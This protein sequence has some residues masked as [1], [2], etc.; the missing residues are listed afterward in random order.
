LTEAIHARGLKTHIET[1]GS[2]PLSGQWDWITLSPKKF[3]AALPE[4]M[5]IAD[6]LKVVVYHP[7]DLAWAEEHA[8][9]TK[10][11]CRLFLQPEWSKREQ[12]TPL[13]IEHIQQN[14]RWTLSLQVHKYLGLP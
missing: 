10:P 4:V 7:S 12:V 13:I 1:S 5:A 14:P 3:K 9:H 11:G 6:E 8:Q 2:H